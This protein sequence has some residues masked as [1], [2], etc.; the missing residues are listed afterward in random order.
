M[1]RLSVTILPEK[2]MNC[3]MFPASE[4]AANASRTI[5][6]LFLDRC[7]EKAKCFSTHLYYD[8]MEVMNDLDDCAFEEPTKSR[9]ESLRLFGNMI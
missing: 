2:S 6:A 3:K 8:E 1:S 5:A 9:G 4:M 7:K